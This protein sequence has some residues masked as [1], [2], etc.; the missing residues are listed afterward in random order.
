MKSRN[1]SILL[2]TVFCVLFLVTYL[3][4]VKLFSQLQRAQK[5]IKAYELYVADSKDFSKYV[6]DNK[7]KELTYLVEKQ[8]KSQ[9]RSKID[10]AKVA[11]R[12]GNYADT[13]SL[14]REIK[15]IENPWLDEVY[16]YL[17][18]ALLKVGEVESAKLYLSSFLDSFTYSVYR[19]EALMI[20]REIADGE[21][22][23]KVQDVLKNLGEF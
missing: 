12:N 16:F 19:K 23:K 6:E 8:M 7:L 9:I 14:L 11:Y 2:A 15:D 22:K 4:N 10:T 20:L 13:V 17:G 3:Y 5:L 18:S 1:L 21:L